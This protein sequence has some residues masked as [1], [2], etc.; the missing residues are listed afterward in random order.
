MNNTK[1][2]FICA[3]VSFFLVAFACIV[4]MCSCSKSKSGDVIFSNDNVQLSSE[5]TSALRKLEDMNS[6]WPST[7][8]I[9]ISGEKISVSKKTSQYMSVAVKEYKNNLQGN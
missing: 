2:S 4:V 6:S 7:L 8:I 3:T 9:S 5:E 1:K